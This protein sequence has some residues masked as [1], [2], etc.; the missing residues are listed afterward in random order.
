M[1]EERDAETNNEANIRYSSTHLQE[2]AANDLTINSQRLSKLSLISQSPLSLSNFIKNH[3]QP[4]PEEKSEE[5]SA[6]LKSTRISTITTNTG[7]TI[8]S[9]DS[10]H[11]A[12]NVS[13]GNGRPETEPKMALSTR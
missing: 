2:K 12:D 5:Q 8:S 6:A 13:N 4:N 1:P 9:N 10:E 11:A 7:T 3:S